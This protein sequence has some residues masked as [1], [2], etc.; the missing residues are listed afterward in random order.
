MEDLGV[1]WEPLND[2]WE[3]NFKL[4]QQYKHRNGNC[5]VPHRY[6]VNGGKLGI[7]LDTQRT[8]KRNN[9]LD[10]TKEKRLDALGVIWEPQLNQWE[11]KYELLEQ[12]KTE[13]G[14]CNVPRGQKVDRKYRALGQWLSAQRVYYRKGNLETERQTKLDKLGVEWNLK[15][16]RKELIDQ[17]EENFKLLQQYKHTT[18]NCNVPQQYEDHGVNLGDWLSKQRQNRKNNRLDTE[19][20]K[21][22]EYLGV[23]WKP[24]FIDQWEEN[25]KLLEQFKNEKGHCNVTTSQTEDE[26]Y[27][28]L[29]RWLSNQRTYYRTGKLSKER[30]LKLVKLGVLWK[31][32]RKVK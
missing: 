12:F 32:P 14:H 18:G 27:R 25:F 7:W 20:E 8:D 29:G 15:R 13:K 28:V 9:R 1:I 23:I 30:R 5:N 21:Q 3:E 26:K 17:W 4:L 2:N 19:K 16:N 10:D 6:E 24:S 31:H 11:E 22:L